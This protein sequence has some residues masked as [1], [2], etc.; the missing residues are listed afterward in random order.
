MR[1]I[2]FLFMALFMSANFASCTPTSLTDSTLTEQGKTGDD[3]GE[4]LPEEAEDD[5]D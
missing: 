1:I 3:D 4:I 2:L 5:D